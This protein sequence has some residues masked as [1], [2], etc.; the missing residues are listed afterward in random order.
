LRVELDGVDVELAG[1]RI[2]EGVT[3]TA[4][5][6]RFVGLVG[7]NG[8][9]KTT[10]LRAVNGA[11]NT[12]GSVVVGDDEVPSLSARE[13]SR[14]VATTPQSTDVAFEFSVEEVVRMGR[15]PHVSRFGTDG[16]DAVE[17][18]ME[19]ADVTRFAD[20][21]ISEVSGGERRRVLLARS[22]AQ[23]TPVLLLDEP[24]AS[25][26]VNHAVTTLELVRSLVDEGKTAIAAIHDLNLAGRFCDEVVL[27]DDGRVVASGTPAE[28]LTEE[29][30][31]SVFGAQVHVGRDVATGA[32][33][34]TPLGQGSRSGVADG[35]RGRVH[36]GDDAPNAFH[37]L[38]DAGYE[39]SV[40]VVPEGS[41]T[42]RACEATGTEAVTAEAFGKVPE[43]AVRRATGMAEASDV[44]VGEVAP[45]DSVPEPDVCLGSNSQEVVGLVRRFVE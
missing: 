16:S 10:L 22:L 1:R 39:V 32:V 12:E 27:L 45:S 15:H 35:G 6:S 30:V 38:R 26:D 31:E 20:R 4:E 13:T 41:A 11:V 42:A 9:G 19:R 28:V 17:R 21:R 33:R 2:L 8:A 23:E 3:A 25:L 24:T 5:E 43:E 7:P 40:G 34:V 18:A 37:A 44:L 29:N 14:R 36:L